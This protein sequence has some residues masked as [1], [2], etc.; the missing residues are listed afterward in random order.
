M[1]RL[2]TLTKLPAGMVNALCMAL[3][4]RELV[5]FLPGNRVALPRER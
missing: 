5:R 2:V 1:D 3:R 4:M